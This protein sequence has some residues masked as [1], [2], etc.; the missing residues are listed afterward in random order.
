MSVLRR[1]D[2]DGTYNQTQPR[3]RLVVG[4]LFL[5]WIWNP[6]LIYGHVCSSIRWSLYCF[7]CIPL[8]RWLTRNRGSVMYWL[9]WSGLVL[10]PLVKRYHRLPFSVGQ[11]L[12]Y[13]AAPVL[14]VASHGGVAGSI[15]SLSIYLEYN[16]VSLF[17]APERKKRSCLGGPGRSDWLL[18]PPLQQVVMDSKKEV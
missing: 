18:L 13:Y 15:T 11:P 8:H 5:V 14:P 7:M 1:L 17:T 2:G 9:V 10:P 12:G 6:P 4:F 3:K 16:P